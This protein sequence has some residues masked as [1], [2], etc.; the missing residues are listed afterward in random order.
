MP[1]AIL[2]AGLTGFL[3]AFF[4]FDPEQLGSLY[5]HQV[6]T[7]VC[8]YLLVTRSQLSFQRWWEARNWLAFFFSKLNDLVYQTKVFSVQ[9]PTHARFARRMHHLYLLLAATTMQE[10][11]READEDSFMGSRAADVDDF[12]G[13]QLFAKEEGKSERA[14]LIN[15]PNRPLVVISW[16]TEQWVQRQQ[17]TPHPPGLA[18]PCKSGLRVADPVQARSYQ[19]LSEAVLAI[20]QLLKIATVPVPFPY[21]QMSVI[22]LSLFA[23]T[24]PVVAFTLIPSTPWAVLTTFIVT[25][26]FYAVDAIASELGEPFGDDS[27]D[28]PVEELMQQFMA[29]LSFTRL[30]EIDPRQ[31]A[32]MFTRYEAHPNHLNYTEPLRISLGTQEGAPLQDLLQPRSPLLQPQSP[33]LHPQSLFQPQTSPESIEMKQ[34]T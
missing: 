4:T 34:I 8:A 27:N 26:G 7:I 15:A 9:D 13:A 32:E 18:Q 2:S 21:C 5:V 11:V 22:T 23:I 20:N 28:L 3:K 31:S 24:W 30:E 17:E 33:L 16:I 14:I 29:E 10:C 1:P 12:F 6:L 19:N 25:L